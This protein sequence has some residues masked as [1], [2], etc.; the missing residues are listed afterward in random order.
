VFYGDTLS[1][2]INNE[3]MKFR[4]IIDFLALIFLIV[5]IM[6][7]SSCS[8][9]KGISDIKTSTYLVNRIP[10]TSRY[11]CLVGSVQMYRCVSI[12]LTGNHY[13]LHGVNLDNKPVVA[14]IDLNNSVGWV[15]DRRSLTLLESFHLENEGMIDFL[16]E[17]SII[18]H[19]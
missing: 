19:E 9:I 3:N 2:I 15:I 1:S 10:D 4:N 16:R 17:N 11:T 8:T 13:E 18:N 14:Y 7:L 5:L 12:A 6:S